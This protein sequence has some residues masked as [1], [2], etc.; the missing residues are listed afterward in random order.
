VT[1]FLPEGLPDSVHCDWRE[2]FEEDMLEQRV[3]RPG[4]DTAMDTVV[5]EVT[6][7]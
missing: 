2:H 6:H 7:W 1:Q 5:P 4:L 3:Q